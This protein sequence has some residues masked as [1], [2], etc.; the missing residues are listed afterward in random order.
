MP[1]HTQAPLGAAKWVAG[2]SHI[3]HLLME[4]SV[5]KLSALASPGQAAWKDQSYPQNIL[6]DM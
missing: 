2:E 6:T 1:G 3:I 4:I 5:E